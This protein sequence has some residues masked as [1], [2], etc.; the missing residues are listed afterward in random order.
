VRLQREEG[1]HRE[2]VRLALVADPARLVADAVEQGLRDP[3]AGVAVGLVDERLGVAEDL[4]G[5]EGGRGAVGTVRIHFA[6][7]EQRLAVERQEQHLGHVERPRVVAREVVE[8]CGVG[9]EQGVKAA[10]THPLPHA[11][12]S[13][14]ELRFAKRGA[15]ARPNVLLRHS[16][17]FD[18]TALACGFASLRR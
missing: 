2:E 18:G 13:R 11:V 9:H 14:D 10:G 7:D 5:R 8:V 6:H 12:A 15:D 16:F 17:P 3:V 1:A 4:L